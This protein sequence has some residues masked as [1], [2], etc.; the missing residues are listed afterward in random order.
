MIEVFAGVA[1]LSSIAKQYGLVSSLAVDKVKKRGARSTI[2][3]LD[4]TCERDQSLLEQWMQSPMLLWVHLAPVC[5]TASRARNIRRFHNDPKPLRSDSMPEGLDD[6]SKADQ[7]RVSLANA[8]FAFSCHIFILATSKGVLT[9]MENPSNSY[10]WLTRW[11]KELMSQIH[12][13]QTNFQVCMYGGS[14]DKWTKI[15]ANFQEI[16]AMD[17]KCDRQHKHAPWGFAFNEEGKQVWATS[18]ESRYTRKMCVVLTSLVLQVA[19]RQNLTLRAT[20]LCDVQSNPLQTALHS[21]LGAQKQPK[22]SKM[23][24]LVPD[25]S[26]VATF[27]C[28]D[29]TQLPCALQSKLSS[30]LKLHTKMGVLESVPK[31]SR[32]LR[33]SAY[34]PDCHQGGAEV[35]QA[36]NDESSQDDLVE[37]PKKFKRADGSSKHLEGGKKLPFE[38]AFGLPWTWEDFVQ[39]AGNSVHPF[40]QD[41]GVPEELEEAISFHMSWSEEQL[42]KYRLDWCKKWLVR[43]KQLESEEAVSRANRPKHV[44]EMTK[45]KRVLLTREILVDIGY[46]DIACLELLEAGSSLA[47]DIER[48]DIFKAQYKPCLMTLKQLERD[49]ARRNEYILKMTVSSGNAELDKQLLDETREELEKGWAE[50]PF[51]LDQLDAGST[52]SRR[53]PLVQGNK[54]RMIDDYSISGVNDSCASFNKIDLHVVDTFSSMIRRFFMQ[55]SKSGRSGVLVG[56]T[57]DLKSAYRQVPI[58]GEHLKFSYF[59]IYNCELNQAQIYRLRTLPFGATHSVYSFLRL[60]RML[61]AIAVRGLRLLTTNFY[62]DFI[63][64]SPPGLKESSQN[65]MELVFMLTGWEFARTGKKATQFDTVCRA[66][67]VQFDFGLSKD[68]I[69]RVGNTE[70]R[71]AELISMISDAIEKGSLDKNVCLTLRGKLGFADSFL[72][73]RLGA[74]VLKRLSEHAY[75]KTARLDDDIKLSLNAMS[76]RLELGDPREVTCNAREKWFIYTDAS[77][78]PESR[79]GG[80]GGVLLDSAG[81][82]VSWYGVEL[83]EAFCNTIGGD[84]KDT[85]IYELELLAAILSLNLWCKSGSHNI[86]VWFGDNDSVR[87]ALIKASG[88]G[89]V[90]TALLKFHL[91]DEAERNSLVWF[92]RVPTEANISDF[93]SRL[94]AHP[95]LKDSHNCNVL[96]AERL[97]QIMVSSKLVTRD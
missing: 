6:L 64:T 1:V 22:P 9:T 21:Q 68:L 41:A 91:T 12:T 70:S 72:H 95:F 73:G 59:S 97:E 77:Y 33:I 31:N 37:S 84:T 85:L 87:Y 78:E 49:S 23:P 11:V 18:L 35:G 53:F 39:R 8:L 89:G 3:Q 76:K 75:G 94:V 43:A 29:T 63:L 30:D 15:L 27:L 58:K 45:A 2:F 69:L 13:Y 86:H 17:V 40:L 55:C 42:S 52:I 32:L 25:F 79:C 62:D 50:G 61:Y 56:K 51:S 90:A 47:G 57:Y 20:D 46:E 19:S 96:A 82:L 74:L 67:G 38:V 88:T 36:L 65:G 14:R 10:F 5:G 60:A 66:L 34:K 93:P 48:C 7:E 4:L 44:A 83:K 71:R 26:S 28:A 92:A 24:P 54:T 81:V 80:L 16:E